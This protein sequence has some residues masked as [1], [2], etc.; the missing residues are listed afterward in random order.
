MPKADPSKLPSASMPEDLR[1][2]LAKLASLLLVH[3]PYDGSFDPRIPGAQ[4]FRASNIHKELMHGVHR[5]SLCIV[6]QGAKRVLLG[7]EAFDYDGSRMLVASVDVPVAAQVL[8]ASPGAPYLCLKLELDPRRIAELVLRVYPHGLPQ[9]QRER[10][11]YITQTDPNL[12]EAASRLV[13]LASQP[14][15][16]D[17]LAPLVLDEILIRLLR[18]P[19]GARGARW[20]TS[21]P[22]SARGSTDATS[23]TRPPRTSRGCASKRLRVDMGNGGQ[24][25]NALHRSASLSRGSEI[26][27]TNSYA[28][29]IRGR[30][31]TT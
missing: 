20:A 24:S 9:G 21:A 18:S 5:A 14:E 3:A 17:L 10:A 19:V 27:R 26:T 1:R 30:S 31:G 23:G 22:P 29:G 7:Q 28:S 6:A 11:V 4:V 12:I 2:E 16:A 15:E 25:A 8:K 13:A